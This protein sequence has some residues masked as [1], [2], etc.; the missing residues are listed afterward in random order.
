MNYE[1]SICIPARNE[2]FLKNTIEDIVAHKEA[3]TEVIAVL[4]GEWANPP[5]EQHLDVKIIYVPESIGQRAAQNMAVRLSKA[6]WVAKMDAHV[7]IDQGFD[8]KMIEFMEKHP[9]D[10]C[11]SVMKNLHA[12]E[13]V[14]YHNYCGWT[15]Y[16]GPTP[17]KCGKCGRSD[18]V[19]KRMVW[20]PRRGINSVSYGFDP[21]PH[22]QYF[23][24]YKHRE[25]YL[26]DKKE[27]G[28]TESMSLQGSCFMCSRENYWK[29]N[30]CDESLGSWGNQ[31]IEVACKT[32]LTGGK[33]LVN[34]ET[35]Y[36]HM[37]RTQGV[38]FSFPYPASGREHL[39]TKR[40][41]WNSIKKGGIPGQIY[42]VSWLVERFWPISWSTKDGVKSWIDTD[43]KELKKTEFKP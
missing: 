38:G 24:A 20:K 30:L 27:K 9:E 16:Q 43:L 8:R 36:A 21:E 4:D 33:V 14:C 41:V 10:T 32:W 5:I 11:V 22:F 7:S 19:R 15:K 26:T 28:Y 17:E 37:F 1:L 34:Y 25:P 40:R 6:K 42:P 35:W 3:K 13:W 29:R 18:K 31:G 23:E 12:F 2:V 39:K